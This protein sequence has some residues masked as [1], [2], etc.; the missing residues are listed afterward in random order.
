MDGDG[1]Q[2]R[3]YT[4]DLKW[5]IPVEKEGKP[6][7]GRQVFYVWFDAPIAYFING[8]WAPAKKS[9]LIIGK[10]RF[11]N[12]EQRCTLCPIYG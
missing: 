9:I 6:W 7:E 10:V 3:K 4:R 12:T 1:L 11:M 8:N 5:G 2:D